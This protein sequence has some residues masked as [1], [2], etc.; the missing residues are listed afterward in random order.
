MLRSGSGW[1]LINDGCFGE[2][3]PCPNRRQRVPEF[4]VVGS[5]VDPVLGVFEHKLDV[6]D[7][8]ALLRLYEEAVLGRALAL[9]KAARFDTWRASHSVHR[10]RDR[11][12]K[13]QSDLLTSGGILIYA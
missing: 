13:F 3:R 4:E 8:L 1:L 6:A 2:P 7:R 5:D 12:S 11:A 9:A 10:V